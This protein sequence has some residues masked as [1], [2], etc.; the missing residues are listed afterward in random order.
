MKKIKFGDTHGKNTSPRPGT[1]EY[2]D[3]MIQKLKRD[4]PKYQEDIIKVRLFL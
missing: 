1:F 3:Y 2:F 4:I